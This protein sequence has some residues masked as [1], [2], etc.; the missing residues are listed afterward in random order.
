MA[1]QWFECPVCEISYDTKREADECR[2][3]DL[4]EG[5]MVE[6]PNGSYAHAEDVW[7][8]EDEDYIEGI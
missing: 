7:D 6:L 5:G 8:P 3:T 4:R 1:N 2:A